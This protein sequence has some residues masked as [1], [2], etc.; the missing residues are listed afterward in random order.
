MFGVFS[1]LGEFGSSRKINYY[2]YIIFLPGLFPGLTVFK[3]PEAPG[4]ILLLVSIELVRFLLFIRLFEL[5]AKFCEEFGVKLIR[6][7]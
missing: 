3:L 5:F 1:P 4:L 7:N 2:F 6:S